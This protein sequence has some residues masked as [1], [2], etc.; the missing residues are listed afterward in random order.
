MCIT[1]ADNEFTHLPFSLVQPVPASTTG[2]HG[3]REKKFCVFILPHPIACGILVPQ[4][5]I[6]PMSPEMEDQSPNH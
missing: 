4:P 1:T 5:G 6:Q 3:F 2:H